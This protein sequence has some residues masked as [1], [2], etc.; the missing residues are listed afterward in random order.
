MPN[1]ELDE[2]Q[3]EVGKSADSTEWNVRVTCKSGLT[4][5]ELGVALNSLADDLLHD[6][7]SFDTAPNMAESEPDDDL[8]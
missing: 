1:D 8:H 4:D 5:H 2:V 7:I 3:F 6:K